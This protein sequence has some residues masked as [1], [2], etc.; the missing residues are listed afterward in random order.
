VAAPDAGS[1]AP[2]IDLIR[3]EVNVKAVELTDDVAAHGRFELTVNARAC[4]PR[5]GGD[6]QKVIRAVKE[7]D[8]ERGPDG[9]VT[10]AGIPLLDAEFTERL[11]AADPAETAAL[12]NG[13]GLVVL[14]T[15]LTPELTAEGIVRDL[16]RVAQQARKQAGLDV[17]DRIVLTIDAPEAVRAAVRRHEQYIAGEVLSRQVEYTALPDGFAGVVGDGVEVRVAVRLANT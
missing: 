9:V 5:L 15:A 12:P 8:W 13:S 6:T 2:F 10:A 14:Q 7:G 17:T 1:L 3:D 11:V 16:V 4:G